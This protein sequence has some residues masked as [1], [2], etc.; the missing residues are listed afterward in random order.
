MLVK[1]QLGSFKSVH[2]MTTVLDAGV[3]FGASATGGAPRVEA[4]QEGIV[5]NGATL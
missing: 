4:P 3:G 1:P 5:V 2:Q